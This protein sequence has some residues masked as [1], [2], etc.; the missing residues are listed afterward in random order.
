MWI[1]FSYNQVL[2]EFPFLVIFHLFFPYFG[3]ECCSLSFIV[4][5]LGKH[6]IN[7]M[8]YIFPMC[9]LS[10]NFVYSLFCCLDIL[11]FQISSH[12]GFFIDLETQWNFHLGFQTCWGPETILFLLF[13][14]MGMGMFILNSFLH[15]ESRS[16]YIRLQIDRNF[17][18]GWM[19][20]RVS[21]MVDLNHLGHEI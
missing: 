18:P 17:V 3:K 6:V 9:H 7:H 1:I 4:Y 11:N 5:M 13:S 21:V 20:S 19:K 2:F 15:F 12:K 14:T 10:F 16:S 8:N